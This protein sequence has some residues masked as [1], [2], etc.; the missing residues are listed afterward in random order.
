LENT[1]D[2]AGFC[3][4][5]PYYHYTDINKEVLKDES[6][7]ELIGNEIAVNFF[8]YMIVCFAIFFLLCA[9]VCV[10]RCVNNK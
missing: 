5:A 6:C 9:N 3:E 1:F 10:A 8:I 4:R 2:C 7:A